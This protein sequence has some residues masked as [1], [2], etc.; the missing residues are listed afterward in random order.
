MKT[1]RW[2][3]IGCGDVAEIKSGPG[4]YKADHSQLVAVM[5]RNGAL[6]A[7]FA[8]RHGVP[9]AY[10]NADAI[11][12][13][14]DIDAVY[15]AT[16]TD[17]H[18]DYTLR[19]AAAGKPVYV[20][21]PMAMNHAEC[22]EMIAACRSAQVPL[23]VGYYRRALPRFLAVKDLVDSGAI[24]TVRM[25]IT[26]QFQ[27]LP[28]AEQMKTLPWRINPALSGGGFFFEMVCHALDFLDFVFGPIETVRA[29]ADNQAK[30]YRPEDA[31][32]ASYRFASGVY[33]SGAWCFAADFDEEYNEIV[34]ASGR[35]RFSTYAPVPI[36]LSRGGVTEDI[37]VA[38]PP[39]VHQ[40]MIQSIVDELNERGRC[41]S[42]GDSGARTAWVL[43]EM[44]KEFRAT[45]AQRQE[46][47][48]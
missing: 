30:A 5:R 10:D 43:D 27:R 25:V 42:T 47:F 37:A 12:Q 4:F 36:R 8:R 38:D 41:P 26:R 34:G 20:E 18:R 14:T 44:L 31:V 24:G 35:I 33:G 48:R 40:P 7:D 13:S 23:W 15:I 11:I 45:D 6:A 19:C 22:A 9:R 2:G 16:L 21:K 39:H 29:F 3:M 46:S 1:I 32:A 28:P 17:S